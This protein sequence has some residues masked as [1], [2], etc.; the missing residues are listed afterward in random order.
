MW[1]FLGLGSNPHHCSSLSNSGDSARS[2]AA[3]PLG[4]S[5]KVSFL[6]LLRIWAANLSI[7]L[8]LTMILA[9]KRVVLVKEV[10]LW[11]SHMKIWEIPIFPVNF[12]IYSLPEMISVP[13]L[14]YSWEGSVGMALLATD[15][16]TGIAEILR[17]IHFWFQSHVNSHSW[18][19]RTM[20]SVA[21]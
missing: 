6:K 12:F 19:T 1:K 20:G 14:I 3:R 5:P 4:N 15:R 18:W 11:G 8:V 17:S 10:S 13:G 16:I 9:K 2:L 7:P 21:Y